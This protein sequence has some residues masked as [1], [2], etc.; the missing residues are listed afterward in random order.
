MEYNEFLDRKTHIGCEHGFDP[1]FMPDDLFPFQ[2]M[3]VEWA[4]RKGRAAVFADCGLGKTF[5]QLVWAENVARHTGGRVL[6]FTPLAVSLQTV[7]EGSKFGIEVTH[8]RDSLHSGDRIVVTNYERLHHFSAEDFVAVVCDES[9]ILKNYDGKTRIAITDFMRK[10]PYRLLCTATA[11]PN[12]YIEL[13]TSSEALGE[14]G[15]ADMMSRFFRKTQKTFT[16]RQEHMSG[17]Y[18]LRGHAEKDFWRWVCSWSRALRKPSDVGFDDD[19]FKLPPL[20]TRHHVVKASK[21]REGYLFDLPAVGLQEQRSDMR[22]T[23]GERCDMV[24]ALVNAHDRPAVAWCNLNDEGRALKRAIPGSE[25]VAGSDSEDRKEQ[26][27]NAFVKGDVRVLVTKP[28]IA[29][30]GMNW[31]HCSHQTFFPSHSYEQFYQATRRS[32][33]FGQKNDVTVDIITTDGQSDILR[34]LQRKSDAAEKM[35]SNLVTMMWRE[36][37]IVQRNECTNDMEVP[38]WLLQ[39]KQ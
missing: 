35:F 30:F 16:R 18:A 31:Q 1:T 36:L 21:P 37:K 19:G 2:R 33:R 29:G 12:D 6:I 4:I 14:L 3:L 38:T 10:R 7:G 26:M 11:A 8:R 23:I 27:F 34:N 5:I 39:S 25:E 28:T 9:S 22:R 32:W 13:G 17:I 24:A 15:S 20:H